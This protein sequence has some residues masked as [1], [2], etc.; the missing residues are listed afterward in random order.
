MKDIVTALIIVLFVVAVLIC[1]PIAL[2]WSLNTL[3]SVLSIPLTFK[4]WIAAFFI[5]V[6]IGVIGGSSAVKVSKK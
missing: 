6:M 5:T 1:T 2:I 3:F 4:T